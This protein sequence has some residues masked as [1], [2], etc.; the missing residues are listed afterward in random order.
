MK[1][2][3]SSIVRVLAG[4]AGLGVVIWYSGGACH[5]QVKPGEQA[6]VA[7][8][9]LPPDAATL[10][11]KAEPVVTRI[12]VVG[13]VTSAERIKLSA[14]LGAYVKEVLVSAGSE[15][16]KGQL[17][18]TLDDR[19]LQE[20]LVAAEVQRK[21][22]ESEF[23][24]TR[25]LFATQAAT[26]QALVAAESAL[27]A[28]KSQAERIRVLLTYARVEA[29]IAGVVTDRFVEAGDLAGPGQMLLAVY[30]PRRMRLEAPVPVRLIDKL[31]LGHELEVRLDRPA[32]TCVGRVAQIVSEVEPQSRTQTVKLSLDG[33]TQPV[34]PGTFGRIFVDD[35]VR[36]CI[37]VPAGAVYRIGQLELVQTVQ[38]GRVLRRLIKTGAAHG[39]RLEVLS[40]LASG[41]TILLQPVQ[42][43]GAASAALER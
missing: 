30:D 13:T 29:P 7:G 31:R 39:A 35:S 8:V 40:G 25:K 34:L 11:V 4:A 2:I 21:Q 43:A 38:E 6:R 5:S 17:L 9:P 42:D 36:D 18:V 19:E 37:L 10:Q 23:E 12:D 3:V 41:E 26:E 33:L 32:L 14:H 1:H 27:N 15:V 24:R 22:A 16:K 20:Q 28:A